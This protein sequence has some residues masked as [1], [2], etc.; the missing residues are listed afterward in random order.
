[1]SV[2]SHTLVLKRAGFRHRRF[3][4]R[5]LHC[6]IRRSGFSRIRVLSSE[7]LPQTL[8]LAD[9][10]FWSTVC[11][12]VR[13]RLSDRC[14]VCLSETLVYCGQMAGWIK[15]ALG[16]EVGLGQDDIVL[17]RDPAPATD[18]GTAAL[19]TFRPMSLVV[20][21]QHLSVAIL[22]QPS[23]LSHG[24][25]IFGYNRLACDR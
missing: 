18:R 22:V 14:P 16:T 2:F 19:S 15:M 25:P 10:D 23:P 6:I 8:S 12:T 1:M 13:P 24:T 11:E 7:A 5:I 20:K 4:R 21:R 9:S 17:D 3:P